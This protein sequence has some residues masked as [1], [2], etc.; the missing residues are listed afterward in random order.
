MKIRKYILATAAAIAT[1]AVTGCESDKNFLEE[2]SYTLN[3]KTFYNS[4]ADVELAINYGYARVQYLLLG[5]MH[6]SCS[7][8]LMGCG[9][10]TFT[11]TNNNGI[12]GGNWDN[13]Y[14]GND[15]FIDHWFRNQ[16]YVIYDMNKVIQTINTKELNWNNDA[17]KNECLA[18]ARFLRGWF[19]R[20][21]AG[22]YGGVPVVT[23]PTE[24][25]CLDF[26]RNT[27]TEVWEQCYEDFKFASENLPQAA[28]ATGRATKAAADHYLAE[29]CNTLGKFDEAIQAATR[30]ISGADG[31][32]HLMTARYGQRKDEST[33]RYGHS[34][35]PYWDLFQIGNQNFE[36]GNNEAI[37]VAQFNY[38]TY[39]TGGGGN[40]WW[41]CR[42]NQAEAAINSNWIRSNNT[43]K[44]IDGKEN[45]R[46]FGDGG[47][48]FADGKTEAS[49]ARPDSIGTIGVYGPA[50]RPTNFFIYNVWN[51]KNDFR[52]SE[53]M[54]QH[55][56]WQPS[57]E[58]TWPQAIADVAR[59]Y[60]SYTLTPADTVGYWPRLWKFSTDKRG[61]ES[62]G[63]TW[64]QYNCDWYIARV[65]ETYLLRA[66][67][68]LGKGDKV[69]AA[70]DINALR[71]RAGA[72]DCSA[73]DVTLDYILDERA[74]E[75]F[76]EEH[77]RVTLSRLSNNPNL[78]SLN[79]GNVLVNRVK[80]YGWNYPNS[81]DG[82]VRPNIHDYDYVFPLPNGFIQSNTGS[83][84]PQNIGW[85]NGTYDNSK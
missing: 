50:M 53:T 12:G 61:T 18:E 81:T 76:G 83:L 47:F 63:P 23:E 80:K 60:P 73:S 28:S 52:G 29:I 58:K 20:N 14:N 31:D 77:R 59:L 39:S 9:L 4:P 27:R 48:Y 75:L 85:D 21:L 45:V 41:R 64:Q 70:N 26:P 19:Y 30:V 17:Q 57:G 11:T 68:Y 82:I 33:D 32:Y 24:E 15:G 38:G 1:L 46:I 25:L 3:T 54:I 55:N 22:L 49:S 62:S 35:N 69:N 71:K 34:L 67:A 79:Y 6:N 5:V 10:D 51:D 65:A 16:Y 8:L 7:W 66:E 84:I 78:A 43:R 36:D 2:K 72:A 56:V 74:R 13:G 37:W 44:T 42:Y 40:S